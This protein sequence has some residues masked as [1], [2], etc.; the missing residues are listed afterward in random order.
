MSNFTLLPWIKVLNV[1]CLLI[2]TSWEISVSFPLYCSA[3][4]ISKIEFTKAHMLLFSHSVGSDSA[5]P[6]TV[7]HQASLSFS[8]S[9]SL[10]KL[11]SIELMISSNNLILCLF[12]LMPS[13]FP[14]I[15]M[16][17]NESVLHISWPSIGASASSSVLP[18][19][20][21]GW[22]PLGLTGL[23]SLQSKG[24]KNLLQNHSSKASILYGPTLTSVHNYWK[25]ISVTI[26]TCVSKM[27]SLLFNTLSRFIIVFLPRNKSLLIS[28]LQSP[29][30]VS[31]R[32]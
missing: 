29:S 24:L 2:A 12:F 9:Q 19:N 8:I 17:S 21:Q 25:N 20:I 26:W 16:F 1:F 13:I 22:F 31:P 14:S 30:T 10:L 3:T 28:W 4:E 11:M 5:T 18:L 7:A 32:K 23:I 27:M 15:R 6:W